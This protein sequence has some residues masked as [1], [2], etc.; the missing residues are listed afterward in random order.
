MKHNI[1]QL[2]AIG[3]FHSTKLAA[4]QPSGLNLQGFAPVE[5]IFCASVAQLRQTAV[6][7]C[8]VAA[9]WDEN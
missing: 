7:H 4:C 3:C 2:T 6:A 5:N 1:V 9:T 8:G